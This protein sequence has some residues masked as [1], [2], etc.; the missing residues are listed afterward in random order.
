MKKT[1]LLFGMLA[2][3]ANAYANDTIRNFMVRSVE[4][5]TPIMTDS[6]NAK[7]EKFSNK[8]L[9]ETKMSTTFD[10]QHDLLNANADGYL[11]LTNKENKN[12]LILSG[13]NLYSDRYT[14]ATITVTTPQ[15]AEIYVDNKL[16]KTKSQAEDSI[17]KAG[18]LT[19]NMD[20]EPMR[21]YHIAIKMLA[22]ADNSCT[23]TLLCDIKANNEK[24]TLTYTTDNSRFYELRDNHLGTR[25]NSVSIS[26]N[27]KYL[28]STYTCN[29]TEKK[30]HSYKVLTDTKTGKVII[31]RLDTKMRWMPR[32]SK[33]YF[34]VATEKGFD[35]VTLDPETNIEQVIATNIPEERFSW[36]PAENYLIYTI[37]EEAIKN[38]G[39]LIRHASASDRV[40]GRG[41]YLFAIYNIETR[42]SERIT[43]GNYSSHILDITDD[44]EKV[45]FYITKTDY[46]QPRHSNVSLFELS[47][48]TF[49][50]D[51]ILWETPLL[52]DA[53]YSP[54]GTKLVLTAGPDAFGG[55]G[56]NCGN[57]EIANNYEGE[58]YIMDLATKKITPISRDFNPSINV[59]C[60]NK[61]GNIYFEG[62]D[63]TCTYNFAY[64]VAKNTWNR[65]NSPAD[66]NGSFTIDQAGNTA[67]FVGRGLNHSSRG[68]LYN[69]KSNK[70]TLFADPKAK[71]FQEIQLG[72][73]EP[74]VFNTEDGT[75]ID[76][77]IVYPPNFDASKKYPM[78]VYY[79][80]GTSPSQ[81]WTEYYYGAHLFA[82]RG[83]VVYVVNPSG[84]T[85][86]GQEFAARHVNAWGKRTA[87]EIIQGTKLVCEKY[88]FIDK[89]HIGC[90]GASYGGF[91]T[92]YLQ[93]LTDIFACAVSHAGISNL[94]S[95]WGEGFWGVGY[96]TV[97]AA[98][99][100]PW[101]NAK[102]FCEQGSL[103][104]ADKINT[105]LL[106][107]HGNKDTNV[108]I[109]ESIQLFNA[110]KLLGKT[111]EFIEVDGENHTIVA[112]YDKQL[113]WHNSTMAW[114]ARWLQ[115]SPEWWDTLYP[116]VMT[117]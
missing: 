59:I 35:V 45:L 103:F 69:I 13:F 76:G 116:K 46:S 58:A 15:I 14:S 81:R 8:V 61:N 74:F 62:D 3:M 80:G 114:F 38:N 111:V 64:N 12:E 52:N 9:L 90:I 11:T 32:T 24:A 97:A 115:D 108:P 106:L 96:N 98:G 7:G 55:I 29:T 72:K 117:E 1:I 33:L 4:L 17:S 53:K 104:N 34:T 91:M 78:I 25:I 48:N 47:L 67:A 44:G 100:Y 28:L 36:S 92:Q 21:L 51:T 56:R 113:L 110:L 85:G 6:V 54:D 75:E 87:D 102:L 2:V 101:N 84:T 40:D 70:S 99:S 109:G 88:D 22:P 31:P 82:S 27:G 37:K 49:A 66:M 41:R 63:R 39:P 89:E 83:Y 105:P 10:E 43:F 60:W 5:R 20:F 94:C 77:F 19:L 57:H 30:R 18:K 107:L 95:Y 93:T 112:D 26:P 71:E 79:Y 23:P 42:V 50:V 68:Y 65:I 73:D 16:K 86:Y